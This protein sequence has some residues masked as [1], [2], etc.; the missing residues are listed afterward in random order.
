MRK[1]RA[2]RRINFA[3]SYQSPSRGEN[4][5]IHTYVSHC[6]T[7]VSISDASGWASVAVSV[8]F[9]VLSEAFIST[10]ASGKKPLT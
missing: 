1:G 5:N 9:T 4:F 2:I 8:N 7:V 6:L 10:M 3:R